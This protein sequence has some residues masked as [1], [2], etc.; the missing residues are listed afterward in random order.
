MD[1]ALSPSVSEIFPLDK[2]NEALDYVATAH[3]PGKTLLR[4]G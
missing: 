3:R 2:A 4:I 1:A